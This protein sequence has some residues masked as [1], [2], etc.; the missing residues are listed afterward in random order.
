[1]KIAVITARYSL[2]GV[3]LAQIRFARAL[4]EA[5]HE[6]DLIHGQLDPEIPFPEIENVRLKS[7]DKDKVRNL[8]WPII[9]YLRTEKP[10]VIFSAEDH[11][12]IVVLIALL[13][14]GAKAKFSGSSRVTPYDTYSKKL[15]SKRWILKILMKLVTPRANVLTCVSEDMVHQYR[16]VF[17]NAPHVCVY[18]IVDDA[19]SRKRMNEAVTEDWALNISKPLV[20]AAGSLEPWKGF[21]DLIN[22]FSDPRIRNRADLVILG[23]GSLR[24]ELESLIDSL[25][26]RDVVTLP[27]YVSNP[28]KFFKKAQVFVLSSYVE[29]LPNV[30]VEAMMC[31]CTPVSTDCPTGPR[32]VLQGG[33]VGYLVPMKDPLAMANAILNAFEKPVCKAKLDAVVAKFSPESVIRRHFEL[34]GIHQDAG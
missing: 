4:Q 25:T 9:G 5:G 1:M 10:D 19:N 29:G 8:L 33:E 17:K 6:V 22:A 27:G 20:I 16:D 34:L 2:T 12:N 21:A 3:P 28:L 15:F 23:D 7:F 26:L 32:E 30:L 24:G 31:G 18:N 11:L 13:L 14:S